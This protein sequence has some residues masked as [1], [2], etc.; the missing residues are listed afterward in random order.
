MEGSPTHDKLSVIFLGVPIEAKTPR[1]LAFTFG[2]YRFVTQ[3]M[4]ANCVKA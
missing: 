1:E 4:I 3:K 2:K